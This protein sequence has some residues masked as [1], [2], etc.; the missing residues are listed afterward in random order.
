MLRPSL[1]VLALAV[2]AG[3]ALRSPA[4]AQTAPATYAE[5]DRGVHALVVTITV[6]PDKTGEF[7]ELMKARIRQSRAEAE[8]VDFRILATDDPQ[9]FVGF[10]SFR[11]PA[12]FGAFAKAPA[13]AAFTE[14]LRP[15]LARPWEVQFLRPL[16]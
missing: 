16:P 3:L 2:S 14:S 12:A 11:G 6:K 13:S 7:L 5:L 8:V 15:L 10:E 9:V 4:T 1:P